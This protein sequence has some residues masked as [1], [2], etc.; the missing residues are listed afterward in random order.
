MPQTARWPHS[1]WR[2]SAS[3]A[4]TGARM[5]ENPEARLTTVLEL[6]QSL[7]RTVQLLAD[8]VDDL[9]EQVERAQTGRVGA[10]NQAARM[11]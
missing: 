3:S 9:H 5:T 2:L 11:H 6:V 4:S 7:T 8:R 1:V 10:W